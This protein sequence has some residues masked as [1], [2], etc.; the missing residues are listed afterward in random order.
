VFSHIT[1]GTPFS[2]AVGST[3]V[4]DCIVDSPAADNHSV[5]VSVGTNPVQVDVYKGTS[6]STKTLVRSDV[7]A[8][9]GYSDHV[10]TVTGE[11]VYFVLTGQGGGASTFD[12]TFGV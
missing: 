7:L 6:W 3:Q 8:G 9:S 4:I 5:L 1:P 12:L 11:T 10:A 2:T